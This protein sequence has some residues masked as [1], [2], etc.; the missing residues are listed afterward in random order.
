MKKLVILLIALLLSPAVVAA[1]G[2]VEF[3]LS[4]PGP[5]ETIEPDFAG[6][7]IYRDGVHVHTIPLT[8]SSTF[9]VVWKDQDLAD[10]PASGYQYEMA[11][12]DTSGNIGPKSYPVTVVWIP[13]AETVTI[14]FSIEV[15]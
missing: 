11:P 2:N 1:V 15:K 13:T 3:E 14:Q 12:I 8:S 7:A 5:G 6:I 10:P 9:P 4:Y